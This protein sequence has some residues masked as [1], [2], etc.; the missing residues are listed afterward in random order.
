[1]IQMWEAGPGGGLQ[2]PAAPTQL[3]MLGPKCPKT[4]SASPRSSALGYWAVPRGGQLPSLTLCVS[5][6]HPIVLL[7]LSSGGRSGTG[8]SIHKSW[9]EI[10]LRSHCWLLRDRVTL[11]TWSCTDTV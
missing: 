8:R 4:C 3:A 6:P 1:M 7:L 10:K 11:S 5:L 9:P 2:L